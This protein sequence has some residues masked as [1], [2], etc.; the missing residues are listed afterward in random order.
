MTRARWVS[1]EKK[2]PSGTLGTITVWREKPVTSLGRRWSKLTP[3][4]G[5]T[6]F[7]FCKEEVNKPGFRTFIFIHGL[8][9]SYREDSP[10]STQCP[11]FVTT[12][13]CHCMSRSTKL[14]PTV[15]SGETLPNQTKSP[16]SSASVRLE[17]RLCVCGR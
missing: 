2:P 5:L 3:K 6:A 11:Y 9:D 15:P 10:S 14:C 16:P 17:T 7:I 13:E 1:G 12:T 4:G 8:E